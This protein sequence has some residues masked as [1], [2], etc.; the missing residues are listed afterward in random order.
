MADESQESA[1][2]EKP[3]EKPPEPSPD[4]VAA[5]ARIA[6]L[7]AAAKDAEPFVSS[8]RQLKIDAAKAKILDGQKLRDGCDAAFDALVTAEASKQG[9]DLAKADDAQL[10][11]IRQAVSAAVQPLKAISK[12][13]GKGAGGEP[14]AKETPPIHPILRL[15]MPYGYEPKD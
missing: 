2:E 6:E 10:K 7:E 12:P 14:I 15:Q 9:I 5:Q 13:I 3:E 11:S 4:L 8:G 1:D